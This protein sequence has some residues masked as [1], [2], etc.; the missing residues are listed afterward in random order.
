M[1]EV[2][3]I[4]PLYNKG[5]YISRA[6]D[7]VFAQTY[8]DYEVI[9]VDDGST[10]NGPEIVRKY[11][12]S[13]LRPIRQDNEGPGAARN[14]AIKESNAAFLAF[15]DADDEWLPGFLESYLKKIELDQS[16]DIVI[17]P[18]FFGAQKIDRSVTWKK[19]GI[20][21]GSWK[22]HSTSTW[23][24]LELIDRLFHTCSALFKRKVIER[25]SGFYC[26]NK[27][28]YSEDKYLWLQVVLNHKVYITMK[29]LFW[30][31][32][33]NSEL[34]PPDAYSKPGYVSPV[35][36][37]PTQIYR[38]C[39]PEYFGILQRYLCHMALKTLS[40]NYAN[41]NLCQLNDLV[42]KLPCRKYFFWKYIKTRLKI[43]FPR[44]IPSVSWRKKKILQKIL[45]PRT[46]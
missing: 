33:E 31:H 21:E 14:R 35:L 24:D 9:V 7:S 11:D 32:A 27:C 2:S 3:V 29:P 46:I 41:I 6:L 44:W 1:P 39:P 40:T 5:K 30:Y 10:D 17:G 23:K 43:M 38:N 18:S 37:D 13:R 28:C 36:T 20:E 15:L 4:I 8:R 25:Y 45:K 19:M 22:L 26:K 16:S 34:Y 42:S 12:D